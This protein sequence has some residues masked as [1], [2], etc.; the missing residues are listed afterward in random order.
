M[1]LAGGGTRR[2]EVTSMIHLHLCVSASLHLLQQFLATRCCAWGPKSCQGL[3]GVGGFSQG[4][5]C[6]GVTQQPAWQGIRNLAARSLLQSPGPERYVPA[7]YPRRLCGWP[8]DETAGVTTSVTSS[9]QHA[10][11]K[12]SD[13]LRREWRRR[14]SVAGTASLEDFLVFLGEEEPGF[15]NRGL[16]W[17]SLLM[18]CQSS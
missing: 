12:A 1:R 6:R 4:W 5:P 14:T 11:L 18:F 8:T 17:P 16:R 13:G 10:C 3:P 15:V 9:I 2:G 7:P